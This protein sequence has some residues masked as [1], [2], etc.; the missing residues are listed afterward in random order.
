MPSALHPRFALDPEIVFLNHGSFGAC[1]RV[2]LEAQ[3][4]IRARM[5]A[6]PVRFFLVDAPRMLDA[7]RETIAGL[8]GASPEDLVFVRNATQAVS[9]ILRSIELSPGDQLLTTDHA[10]GACRN[11]LEHFAARHGA[12]VVVA[13]VP[14]PLR[15]PGE[16]VE[17]IA[18]AATARTR[19]ALIDHVTSP[20][21]LVFP[22]DAIVA[23]LRERGIDTLVDGAH[24]PGM[25]E[26]DLDR[27]GAAYYTGN[28]HKW[29]CA[30]K[31]C[32][33]LHVRRDRQRDLHPLAISHG[34]RHSR[35]RPRLWEEF[36]WTGT[37]DPSAWLC[38]PAALEAVSSMLPGGLPAVRAHNHELALHARDELSTLLGCAQ[39]APDSMIGSLA[40]VPLPDDPRVAPA[41]SAL[42]LD[43][44][45]NRL[46][47]VHRIEV[48][49]FPWPA[50]PSRL[51]R[52]AAQ[53]YVDRADIARLL[54]A[55]RIELG[56]AR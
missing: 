22:I 19:L 16:V 33:I 49:V 15:D 8:L 2:V 31:G 36:D 23:L 34:L 5:E 42:D 1:P 52:V 39:P 46:F 44:L 47:E 25:L 32:A 37:D 27:L 11:A 18:A 10:Y 53:V 55:L 6:E 7:A 41:C 38:A 21:G 14:F 43:P 4:A 20:T 3:S 54:A 28:L 13:K 45:S 30:P 24:A 40:A 51:I 50:L 9:T 48:P 12:K 29:L 26:L 35:A 17:R 56:L